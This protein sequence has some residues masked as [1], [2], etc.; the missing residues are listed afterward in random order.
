MLE[1]FDVPNNCFAASLRPMSEETGAAYAMEKLAG[2]IRQENQPDASSAP[3]AATAGDAID[4][5]M[6]AVQLAP[7]TS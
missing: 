4:T 5:A 3:A 6:D 7:V 1:A 2:D